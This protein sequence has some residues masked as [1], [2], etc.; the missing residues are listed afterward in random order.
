MEEHSQ[1]IKE[2]DKLLIFSAYGARDMKLPKPFYIQER[3]KQ[4]SLEI[5]L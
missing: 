1:F 5:V 4:L 2:Q 3:R